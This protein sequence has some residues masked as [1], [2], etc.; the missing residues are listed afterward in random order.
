M[1]F[2]FIFTLHALKQSFYFKSE[3]DKKQSKETHPQSQA[4]QV[5]VS[6]QVLISI[7]YPQKQLCLTTEL[8]RVVL[9]EI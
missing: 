8:A 9:A 3:V 6:F 1:L 5:D 7:A 2:C 4:V